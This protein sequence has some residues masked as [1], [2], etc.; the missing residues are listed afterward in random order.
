MGFQSLYMHCPAI[1]KV[2][3]LGVRGGDMIQIQDSS[4]NIPGEHF[5]TDNN[6]ECYLLLLF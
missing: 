2:F 1:D 6:Q 5:K 3:A 4:P